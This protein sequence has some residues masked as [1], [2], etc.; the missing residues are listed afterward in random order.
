LILLERYL[1]VVVSLLVREIKHE[2]TKH[3]G[4]DASVVCASV[5]DQVIALHYVP[6]ELQLGDFFT[7][8]KTRAEHSFFLSNL[9]D[10]GMTPR[11]LDIG[12][13]A[14]AQEQDGH[15][16]PKKPKTS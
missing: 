7:K 8:A 1:Y 13:P 16:K 11:V 4:V 14:T 10:E 9:S 2:L 12:P 3:I 15:S 5:H 6:Q